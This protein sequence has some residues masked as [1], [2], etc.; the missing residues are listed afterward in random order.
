[1]NE[2][3]ISL[4][5]QYDI[6]VL[7]TRKG[8]GA[9]IFETKQGTVLMKEYAGHPER[10]ALEQ[11]ILQQIQDRGL[12]QVESLLP[13]VE[14]QWYV[15]DNEGVLY[16]V[17]RSFE[18]RE[19]DVYD[20]R[21]CGEAM[22]T[23]AKLH[24]SMEEAGELL[25]QKQSLTMPTVSLLKEYEK[26]NKELIR[27]WGYLKKKGQK[28]LFERRL[29]SV[30]DYFIKQARQVTESVRGLESGTESGPQNNRPDKEVQIPVVCHGDFQYHNVIRS[31]ERWCILNFEKMAEDYPV[32]DVYLFLRKAMEKNNW[33]AALGK[34]MLSA[35]QLIR[36]LKEQE[37]KDLYHRFAYPEKFW[38]IA[39]F[40]YNSGKAWIPEK[41]L[42]K[43]EK[44]IAQEQQKLTFLQEIFNDSLLQ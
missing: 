29:L 33:S 5:E 24:V 15:K 8:R 17:K 18:G 43:L 20:G 12:V 10:L 21:E 1:V 27:I 26:H 19:C 9:F 36:V 3:A 14:G 25:C 37:W 7:R 2:R 38:K 28:Q 31:Q 34:E 6:E 44:V 22:Q 41:N 11:Q 23:L 35:Y 13:T 40:Y 39:N 32:R 42:E 30:M 4:I 16:I